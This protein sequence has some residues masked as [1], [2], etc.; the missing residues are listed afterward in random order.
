MIQTPIPIHGRT[1]SIYGRA[2]T[3]QISDQ[4]VPMSDLLN[5]VRCNVKGLSRNLEAVWA[6]PAAFIQPPKVQ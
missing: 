5:A 3:S 1:S 4:Q 6:C 2:V